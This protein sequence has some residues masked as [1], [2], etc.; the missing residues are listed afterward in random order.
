MNHSYAKEP[1][2]KPPE[3]KTFKLICLNYASQIV[4]EESLESDVI[5]DYSIIKDDILFSG[6][7]DV[8]TDD[9]EYNM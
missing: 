1:R 9:N 6:T 8:M 2:K 5:A 7:V 4:E 3:Q